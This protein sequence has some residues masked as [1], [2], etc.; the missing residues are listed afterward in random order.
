MVIMG[1]PQTAGRPLA[2]RTGA[3]CLR[4]CRRKPYFAG[5]AAA[6]LPACSTA[7]GRWPGKRPCAFASLSFRGAAA[8]HQFSDCF[9]IFP[10]TGFC[11]SGVVS[12]QRIQ[13]SGSKRQLSG[14]FFGL[15]LRVFLY[16]KIVMNSLKSPGWCLAWFFCDLRF[17]RISL[18]SSRLI[19]DLRLFRLPP[20][21]L[22]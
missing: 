2:D 13:K 17:V 1:I 11:V 10:L 14:L 15:C 9:S 16:G 6:C 7:A 12:A 18:W 3:D 19:P 22:S 21:A 20:M 4:L 8:D 5:T